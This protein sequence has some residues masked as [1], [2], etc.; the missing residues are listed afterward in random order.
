MPA[1]TPERKAAMREAWNGSDKTDVIALLFGTSRG[2]LCN[3][4]KS[5]GWPPRQ[6]VQRKRWQGEML[7]KLEVYWT[8][9]VPRR[10]I[11]EQL[12]TSESRIFQVARSM[13][14]PARKPGRRRAAA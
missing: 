13:G 6:K 3:I 10:E 1:L 4:A 12:G 8:K 14:L 11:A 5:E 2:R 9:G 7:T